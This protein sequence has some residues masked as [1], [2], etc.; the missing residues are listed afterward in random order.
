MQEQE[1]IELAERVCRLKAES[2]TVEVKAASHGCPRHLY[3]SLSSFS[4]QDAGGIL[5]FGIDE[6]SG[7][8]PVGVYDLQDLQKSVTEQ[9]L[10]MEP[11]VR[12]VFTA[13]EYQGKMICSA[14]IPAVDIAERPCYYRG[15]GRIRGSYV[16]VGDAD[17]PMTDQELYHFEAFRRHL[18][19]DER[20]AERAALA[21]LD[22][23]RLQAY[24]QQC[25]RDRPGFARLD[26]AQAYEMLNITR[27]GIPTLA[28]VLNFGIYPQGFFPQL[29][30][31]AVVPAG[32]EIGACTAEGVRFLDNE[33]IEGTLAEMAQ[34]AMRFCVRNMKK[35]TIINPKTGLREDRTE[36][37]LGAVREAILNALIHRD[38][39]LYS[40]SI[41]IQI[42]MFP[43]RLEI[44]SPGG[45]YGR[46]TLEQL[47]H[48]KLD[49][50]N[51]A[52]AVMTESLTE[53]ENRSSGIPTMRREMAEY[54]LPAPVFE[55]RREEFAVILYSSDAAVPSGRSGSQKGFAADLAAFCE[56][57]RS[58]REIASHL[59]IRTIFYAD[60]NYIQPLVDSGIL[61][62]TIPD[63]PKSRLQRYFTRRKE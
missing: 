60:R 47:G 8:R 38:Y 10:Q 22:S 37:P 57:P 21:L 24:L 28:A 55:N 17:L 50:R 48:A 20:P 4:N 25:R 6:K 23:G 35:R 7:F 40:E 41:P 49:L 27:N 34:A 58:R 59:G 45:L 2:Q 13:A 52:L 63:R 36:Y 15:I 33:R 1:L 51:P 3:D 31:T 54:G 19:D 32:S 18:H 53:A 29:A 30:I 61:E 14:E 56:T 39:S 44:H 43:D 16:R 5:L 42:L 62:L 9:C 26:E 12:A 11:A 46:M